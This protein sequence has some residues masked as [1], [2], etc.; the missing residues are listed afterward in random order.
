MRPWRHFR[1]LT[2]RPNI[3][4]SLADVHRRLVDAVFRRDSLTDPVDVNRHALEEISEEEGN[5]PGADDND[6]GPDHGFK[7]SATED[8]KTALMIERWPLYGYS[9]SLRRHLL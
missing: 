3:R 6:S 8:S 9:S 4:P 1:R 5:G 7:G 2:V